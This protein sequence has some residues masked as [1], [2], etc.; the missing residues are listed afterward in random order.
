MR[1]VARTDKNC[2]NYIVVQFEL[3]ALLLVA[4]SI[5]APQAMLIFSVMKGL[6]IGYLPWKMVNAGIIMAIIVIIIDLILSKSFEKLRLPV[7]F[8]NF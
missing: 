3:G 7:R 6:F 8:C 5:P 1:G 4:Y 2:T